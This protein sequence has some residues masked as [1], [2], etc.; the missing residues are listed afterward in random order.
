M[1]CNECGKELKDGAKFCGYCGTKLEQ[2]IEEEQP[3]GNISKKQKEKGKKKTIIII[4][5]ILLTIAL[6]VGILIYFNNKEERNIN[7]EESHQDSGN[8]EDII[9]YEW[10]KFGATETELE[11]LTGAEI[12]EKYEYILYDKQNRELVYRNGK[13]TLI[14][15]QMYEEIDKYTY[16]TYK[17]SSNMMLAEPYR[18]EIKLFKSDGKGNILDEEIIRDETITFEEHKQL[19]IKY[20]KYIDENK[21]HRNKEISTAE[22]TESTQSN[23]ATNEDKKN[24]IIYLKDVAKPGDYIEY[25]LEEKKFT[26]TSSESGCNK[27]QE[28]NTSDYNGTWQFLYNNYNYGMQI[29]STSSV[30]ELCLY[31][32]KGYNNAVDI[33]NSFSENYINSRYAISARSIGSDPAN[34]N[35][36]AEIVMDFDNEMYNGKWKNGD[37]NYIIDREALYNAN[38]GSRSRGNYNLMLKSNKIEDIRNSELNGG[39]KDSCWLASRVLYYDTDIWGPSCKIAS[40]CGLLYYDFYQDVEK[41]IRLGWFGDYYKILV[42]YDFDTNTTMANYIKSDGVR[43]AIRLKTDLIVKS[44]DGTIDNPYTVEK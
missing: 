3:K 5:C 37:K 41:S 4:S 24:E 36:E 30:G 17:L 44:G 16:K 38:I 11:N 1:Y 9:M 32:T 20:I 22:Y 13:C 40:D 6:I 42:D 27:D 8:N 26:I 28:F 19:E 10:E 39:E 18:E 21:D 12:D 35:D 15:F 33:L 34:P 2:K 14:Y 29:V 7:I 43:P 25:E 31:G 23:S